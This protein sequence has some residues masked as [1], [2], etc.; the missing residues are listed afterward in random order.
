MRWQAG[1]PL[2]LS[3]AIE[4][5]AKA[6]QEEHRETSSREG[7]IR[8]FLERKVPEDWQ[9]WPVERRRMF[10]DDS[11]SG[12]E[13]LHL[14]PRDRVCALEVWCEAFGGSIKEMKNSDTREINA[15]IAATPEWRKNERVLRF[16]CYGVQRGF[17]K[18][19]RNNCA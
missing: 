18:N 13:N 9:S 15:I 3:G 4:E 14:V 5:A 1:E 2:Y 17:T 6:K 11:I 8:E 7:I 16:G 12:K 19:R 10:F